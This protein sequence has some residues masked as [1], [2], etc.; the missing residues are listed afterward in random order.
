LGAEAPHFG[1]SLK[2]AGVPTDAHVVSTAEH[3]PIAQDPE[4]AAEIA[5]ADPTAD[6]ARLA[7]LRDLGILDTEPEESFDRFTRLAADLLGVP[8]AL[9]SL[10]DRDRQFFKSQQ[11][12]QA[13]W[14]EAR[15]TPL[16]HSFC[17]YAVNSKRPLVIEDARKSGLVSDSLAIRDLDLIAYAGVPL[18]LEDGHVVGTFCAI[19]RQPHQWTKFELRVL[20]DLAQAVTTQLD[21]RR[22]LAERS[23]NDRLTGLPNRA[24]TTAFCDHVRAGHRD[25]RM[26]GLAIA[27]DDAGIINQTY[28]V[29]H[30]DRV[31]KRVSRRIAWQL[32]SEDVLGRIGADSFIVIRPDIEHES[33]ALELARKLR[34]GICGETLT[35]KGDSLSIGITV[36]IA[37]GDGE[38]TGEELVIHAEQAMRDARANRRHVRV[39]AP[40]D[41]EESATRL[42]MRG[43]LR[44]AVHRDEIT[45]AFQPIVDLESGRTRGFEALARWRHPEL[46]E[47]SPTEFIPVA[48][49]SGDIVGIGEHVLRTSCQQLG[50]W[51]G[52]FDDELR[53]TVN[54]SPVQL[55][56]P[57][58]VEVIQGIL[59]DS[60][61][62]GAALALEI[63]EGVLLAPGPL[64]LRNLERLRELGIQ[65]ALDDFGTGYSTLAYL[66][67]FAVDVIKIDRS[68]LDSRHA[69]FR[70]EAL[71]RA[72]L[73]FG[74][75]MQIEV[76]AEGV[77][78]SSQRDLLHRSGC[79]YGQGFLF[80]HPLP[81]GEVKI[82]PRRFEPSTPPTLSAP[83]TQPELAA[84]S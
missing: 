80:A 46:G 36:G 19:D 73:A 51:R 24:L 1:S 49:V 33:E 26:L 42:R 56:V 37:Y 84:T 45:V 12:L 62:P 81:A 61:V 40:E 60:N 16:S 11:G 41:A 27:V 2:T 47:V 71:V 76:V 75:G 18:V 31:L 69:D 48:E 25:R 17:Q 78:T 59:D 10:V 3:H 6:G 35:V 23:L 43:A 66:K 20:N 79:R 22:A 30:A 58:I 44:G 34:D 67:S 65:I 32:S 57:N 28:G 63:T 14:S 82:G 74:D 7:A 77:E 53:L 50:S 4:S 9:V 52:E 15:Q 39:A 38:T 8:V 64:E 54:F 72:I 29:T 70:G 5:P 55:A 21:L 68:F 13:P 83:A